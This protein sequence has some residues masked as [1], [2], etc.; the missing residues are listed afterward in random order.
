MK[1]YFEQFPVRV[2][3]LYDVLLMNL[4]LLDTVAC[5]DL[6]GE[7]MHGQRYLSDR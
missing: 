6:D 7:R 3:R 4:F 5:R 1:K 2:P